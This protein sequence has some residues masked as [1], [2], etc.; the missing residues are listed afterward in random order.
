MYKKFKKITNISIFISMLFIFI[1][2]LLILFP[3]TSLNVLGY[4]LAIALMIIGGYLIGLD[5]RLKEY[6]LV[7]LFP[8]GVLFVILGIIMIIHPNILAII[9]PIVLGIYFILT[10]SF[11]LKLSSTLRSVDSSKWIL[12]FLIS[13]LAI[14]CGIILIA[15]PFQ[16]S[17]T[18][19]IFIGIIMIIYAICNIIDM[20]YYKKY[21]DE[22][23]K[24]Y[25]KN[26]K[27]I[28]G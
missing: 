10:S 18:I 27:I 12:T 11:S 9:I 22:I 17:I 13:V 7:D 6:I 4:S 25:K 3:E 28:E 1:G 24:N 23:L 8:A 14:I 5:M 26:I 19:T 16:T 20:L 2:I 21:I 15:N